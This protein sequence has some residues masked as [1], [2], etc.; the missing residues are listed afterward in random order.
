[1]NNFTFFW[2]TKSPFSQWHPVGFELNGIHY[3]TAEHYMMWSKAMLFNDVESANEVLE[4]KHPRDV[5]AIGR[6]VKNFNSQVWEDNC[7]QIVY[8]GNDAKF[9]QNLEMLDALMDTGS[10][11]LVEAS[12]YD[13]IWGIGLTADDPRALN[14]E[15]WQ[16]TNYLGEILTSLREKLRFEFYGRFDLDKL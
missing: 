8:T 16:G 9:R 3:S 10:T 4:I 13:K 11:E 12:P 14:K 2:E 1:M 7:K 6:K 5:K 15:T